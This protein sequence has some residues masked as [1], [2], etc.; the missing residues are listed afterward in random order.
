MYNTAV[1]KKRIIYYNLQWQK[2]LDF[3]V[4]VVLFCERMRVRARVCV[5]GYSP[6]LRLR[7]CF[8]FIFWDSITP[9]TRK[10]LKKHKIFQNKR[11]KY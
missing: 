11:I 9:K 2:L 8:I 1:I 4:A 6:S 5:C 7:V 10:Q 3:R